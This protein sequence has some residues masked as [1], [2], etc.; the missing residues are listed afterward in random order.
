MAV[1]TIILR[2]RAI[3]AHATWRDVVGPIRGGAA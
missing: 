3:E 2:K 1:N